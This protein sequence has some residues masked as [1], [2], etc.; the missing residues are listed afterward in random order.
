MV[1][2]SSFICKAKKLIYDICNVIINFLHIYWLVSSAL[3]MANKMAMT[4]AREIF[5]LWG[6]HLVSRSLYS[7]N[8]SDILAVD[9]AKDLSSDWRLE[10]C[11]HKTGTFAVR[12]VVGIRN[13]LICTTHKITVA[14]L[15]P[16][17]C[18]IHTSSFIVQ[19]HI[20]D[21]K[22]NFCW[23]GKFK[24]TGKQLSEKMLITKMLMS[25]APFTIHQ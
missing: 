12:D 6:L 3:K 24:L 9:S 15:P 17:K 21:Q 1:N 5:N 11:S 18:I 7:H 19:K 14:T 23:Q 22:T 10:S 4:N 8:T 25:L 2:V 16:T 13:S 20:A